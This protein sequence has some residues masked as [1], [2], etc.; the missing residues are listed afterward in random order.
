VRVEVGADAVPGG[1]IS[2]SVQADN[3]PST[4]IPAGTLLVLA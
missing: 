1:T 2:G 3:G 4:P